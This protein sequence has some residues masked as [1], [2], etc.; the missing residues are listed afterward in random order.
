MDKDSDCLHGCAYRKDIDGGNRVSK[1][2]LYKVCERIGES[3]GKEADRVEIGEADRVEI[4]D[5]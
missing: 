3:M 4:D 5:L 2:V 1:L